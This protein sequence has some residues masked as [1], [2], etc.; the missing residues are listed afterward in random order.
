M[1]TI[2]FATLITSQKHII[3]VKNCKYQFDADVKNFCRTLTLL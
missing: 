2:D 1:I 3:F